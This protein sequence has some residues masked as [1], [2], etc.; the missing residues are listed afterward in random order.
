MAAGSFTGNT[1]LAAELS[2][3]VGAP[4]EVSKGKARRDYDTVLDIRSKTGEPPANPEKN[5]LCTVGFKAAEANEGL[6]QDEINAFI[7]T[8][9]WREMVAGTLGLF[10]DIDK[11]GSF[12]AGKIKGGE[13][14]LRPKAGPG[15]E[16]ARVFMS[17]AE[18]PRGRTTLVC[19]TT[20][21]AFDKAIPAFRKIRAGVAIP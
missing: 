21:A 15:H 13:F 2:V 16:N 12:D 9:D 17:I 4:F 20:A 6:T 11:D 5:P 1:S 18:T 19:A 3:S 10:F 8:P 14:L 7:V